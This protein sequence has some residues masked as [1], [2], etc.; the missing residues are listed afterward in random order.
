M[1]TALQV[2]KKKKIC[3][4]L[5]KN[6]LYIYDNKLEHNGP[7]KDLEKAEVLGLKSLKGEKLVYKKIARGIYKIEAAENFKSVL[8]EVSLNKKKSDIKVNHE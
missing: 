8:I 7:Y 4:M 5:E 2:I 6:L 3:F 1:P